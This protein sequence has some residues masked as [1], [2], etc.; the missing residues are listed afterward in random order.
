MVKTLKILTEPG[1]VGLSTRHISL[2]TVGLIPELPKLASEVT[3]GLTVSLNA[4]DDRTRSYL[5]PI[6]RR[7]PMEQLHQAPGGFS[8]APGTQD[9]HCLRA[10]GPGQ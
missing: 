7:Y 4:A 8:P 5:M 3:L 2:S 6:N 10:I 9:H 1:L